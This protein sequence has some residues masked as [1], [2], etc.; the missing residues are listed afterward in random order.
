VGE[1]LRCQGTTLRAFAKE[2]GCSHPFL[3]RV[4]RGERTLNEDDA[5]RWAS[6]L[7]LS[8]AEREHFLDLA[9]LEQTPRRIR[10]R[11]TRYEAEK[12]PHS[13]G[14]S[15]RPPPDPTW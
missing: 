11:I 15:L 1:L 10:E 3:S 8:E 9:A 13:P 14:R 7:R 6:C 12:T 5:A 4:L 2:V